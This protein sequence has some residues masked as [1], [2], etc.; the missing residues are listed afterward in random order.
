MAASWVD[1]SLMPLL[2]PLL[3]L[4]WAAAHLAAW[5]VTF[6]VVPSALLAKRMQV[7]PWLM[8]PMCLRMRL[9]GQLPGL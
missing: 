3:L 8:C 1:Y 9:L 4:Y 5:L 2:M 6:T 7:K